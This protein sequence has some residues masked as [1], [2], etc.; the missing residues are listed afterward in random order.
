MADKVVLVKMADMCVVKKRGN[1]SPKL[2]TTLGSC[3][4]VVLSDRKRG[5]HG[6]VH[7]MLPDR[8]KDDPVIG[9]YA[10]TAIP[11]LIGRMEAMGSSRE[12]M[13]AY[14][15]GGACM[16]NTNNGSDI[17]RIGERNVEKSRSILASTGVP[18]VFEKT[19][20]FQGMTVI[21]DGSTGKV[22]V[23]K[24]AKEIAVQD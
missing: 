13:K 15:V 11:A 8:V 16:F 10:D 6:M 18:V 5:I 4:G 3:V 22:T 9:K 2:K 12:S 20:G 24:L 21:F 19:G 14:L 23:R 7:I 1:G 17:A